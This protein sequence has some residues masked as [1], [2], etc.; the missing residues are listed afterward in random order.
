M[1]RI[2]EIY[3]EI[4]GFGRDHGMH[5]E[6]VKPGEVIYEMEVQQ[7]HLATLTVIH[8]GMVAAFMDA[9]LGVAALS[10][11]SLD[12]KLVSTIEFKINFFEPVQLGDIMQGFGQVDKKGK[13]IYMSSGRIINK[14]TKQVLASGMGTFNTY[15]IEKTGL[16]KKFSINN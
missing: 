9:V 15:P 6:V 4:N 11:S 14:K 13:S 12:G 3:E 5:F 10:L 1:N 7:K 2:L 16:D 8:G